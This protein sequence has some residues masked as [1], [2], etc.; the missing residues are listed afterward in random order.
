MENKPVI[1]IV[2]TRCTPEQEEKFHKWYE[3]IHIPLLFE[4]PGMTEVKRWKLLNEGDEYPQYLAI[5]EFE[6][7]SALEAWQTSPERDAA[8]KE[9]DETWKEG[10]FEVIWRLSYEV[11]K[12]WQR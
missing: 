5:Y 7:Q 8:M 9:T 4:F 3:E 12:T 2:G 1:L 11:L 6:S 10:K